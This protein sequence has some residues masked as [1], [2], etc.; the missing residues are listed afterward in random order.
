MPRGC[1]PEGQSHQ[2]SGPIRVALRR[3]GPEGVSSHERVTRGVVMCER[4]VYAKTSLT[5]EERVVLNAK[6]K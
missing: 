4:S 5:F 3:R 6:N 2:P 1:W